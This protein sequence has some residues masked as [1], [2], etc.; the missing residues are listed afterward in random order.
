LNELEALL[1]D[2][3]FLFGDRFSYADAAIAPF[4][5]QFASTDR[6]WFNQRNSPHLLAWLERFLASDSFLLCMKKYKQW[7]SGNRPVFFPEQVLD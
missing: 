4:V 6:E 7:Y 2:A 3:P 5:R 1:R